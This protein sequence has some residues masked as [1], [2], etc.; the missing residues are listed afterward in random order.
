LQNV[1]GISLDGVGDGMPVRRSQEQGA[2]DQ[3]VE[4]ALQEFD[5]LFIFT[6]RHSR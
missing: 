4:G 2:K 3:H 5:A 1:V 6:S